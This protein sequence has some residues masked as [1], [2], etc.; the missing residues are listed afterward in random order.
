MKVLKVD[1]IFDKKDTCIECALK[2]GINYWKINNSLLYA[3]S[4][5]FE[6]QVE[7]R[8]KNY[9]GNII[10]TNKQE[11]GKYLK[12]E[13]LC[14][15]RITCDHYFEIANI[16]SNEIK[17]ERPVAIFIDSYYCPWNEAYHKYHFQ[18]YCLVIGI[19][20][21]NQQYLCR[22]TYITGDIV[23]LPFYEL[24]QGF[25]ECICFEMSEKSEISG[26]KMDLFKDIVRYAEKTQNS[27]KMTDRIRIFGRDIIENINTVYEEV[28]YY[29]NPKF[30]NLLVELSFIS[31]AREKFAD[32][33]EYLKNN[34]MNDKFYNTLIPLV[35]SDATYWASLRGLLFKQIILR[36][37]FNEE[38][39][40]GLVDRIA[41]SED[42][43]LE[44]IATECKQG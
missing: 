37:S 31:W 43:I 1:S 27:H 40:L 8:G 18:H 26:I 7:E 20:K 2:T 39:F 15:R 17:D 38:E 10:S 22:D 36:K 9:F 41:Q 6:Y 21:E 30:S 33:F 44:I 12:Y 11:L 4:F 23:T 3:G 42:K 25:K 28:D 32:M 13:G 14:L 16:I 34:D 35:R 24:E 19:D 5:N 29:D